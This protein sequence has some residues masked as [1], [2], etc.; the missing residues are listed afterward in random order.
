MTQ[1]KSQKR[2]VR[3]RMARTGERYTTARLHTAPEQQPIDSLATSPAEPVMPDAPASP[4]EVAPMNEALLLERTGR[5]WAE[6]R[7]ILDAWGAAD[8]PHRDIARWLASEHGVE[9]WWCQ[10]ITVSYERA[11]GRRK[12]GQHADGFSVGVTR[13]VSVPVE[14][15]FDA[16]ADET[17]RATWLAGAMLKVRTATSPRSARF[18]WDAGPE[19]VVVGFTPKGD[20][21]SVISL[22]HERITDRDTA[23]VRKAFWVARLDALKAVLEA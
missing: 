10:S 14:R 21:R 4:D 17:E 6:W 5:P 7:S 1:Q 11:I 13:T 18:D 15:L 2:R 22:S 23:D 16:V 12:V 19:R 9:S 20:T 8:R 3:E